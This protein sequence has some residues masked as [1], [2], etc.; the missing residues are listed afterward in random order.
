MVPG[1]AKHGVSVTLVRAFA[2][3][4]VVWMTSVAPVVALSRVAHRLPAWADPRLTVFALQALTLALA[5]AIARVTVPAVSPQAS[6]RSGLRAGAWLVLG[7][8]LLSLLVSLTYVYTGATAAPGLNVQRILARWV[9]GFPTTG[10]TGRLV[11]FAVLGPIFEEFLYRGFILGY[12]LRNAAPWLALTVSTLLFSAGH[13]SQLLSGLL[14]L[15]FGLLYLRYGNL[16]L[17][18]LVHG[19]H[20]LFSSGGV[21]LLI[22]YLHDSSLL[23]PIA[24]SFLWLQL[25]LLAVTLAC[26]GMFLRQAFSRPGPGALAALPGPRRDLAR[27]VSV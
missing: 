25:A 27:I 21:P 13:E 9:D 20:N 14:G 3:A 12:L 7:T 17:C 15:A 16:W 26:F 23:M 5:F 8:L 2:A 4:A 18:V 11:L 22:A 6:L 24:G 19:A 10:L 1:H